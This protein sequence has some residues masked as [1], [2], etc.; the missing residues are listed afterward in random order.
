MD[1]TNPSIIRHQKRFPNIIF[2]Y[3]FRRGGCKRAQGSYSLVRSFF[4]KKKKNHSN[5]SWCLSLN[6]G[7]SSLLYLPVNTFRTSWKQ[8][9][10]STHLSPGDQ[11]ELDSSRWE[12]PF[13]CLY[14]AWAA[15]AAGY[16]LQTGNKSVHDC[17][18][19]RVWLQVKVVLGKERLQ[20]FYWCNSCLLWS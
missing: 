14:Y 4:K 16:V 17:V 19:N 12:E 1:K 7:S 18:L 20:R 5:S 15:H 3:L 2:V 13:A 6:P 10:D 9:P 11:A 8:P